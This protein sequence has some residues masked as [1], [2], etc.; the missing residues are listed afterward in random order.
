[1]K[2]IQWGIVATGAIAAKF[3]EA[4]NFES[5]RAGR[6]I[7]AAVASRD[8]KKAAEFAAKWNIARY[9][10]SYA[11]LFADPAIDAVYIATPH[12]LHAEL[13][14][15]ALEAGKAVLC[16]KPV[17]LDA[18][19]FRPVIEAAKRTNRFFMEAMW[20][21]FNPSFRKA[22]VWIAEGV[23]GEPKYLR[24]DFFLD[25][26]FN[27]E[28]RLYNP[29]LGGGALLDLGIYP[30]TCAA[31]L[32]GGKKPAYLTA[33]MH[34]GSTGVDLY[35]KAHMVWDDGLIADLSSAINLQGVE[36]LRSA[37]II[38][39]TGSIILPFFWMAE[40]AVLLDAQGNEVETFNAPFECNG[41]EYE[42]REVE[43]C[44]I[45]GK[46]ESPVQTW[47]DSIMVMEI[48]DDIRKVSKQTNGGK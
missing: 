5:A 20:M 23:I 43:E 15:A 17:S 48:L 42:I 33:I 40:K 26:P 28:S 37:V 3:A 46:T 45:E 11:E 16:E 21:K 7:L 30:V 13:S 10:G 4:C 1:M 2:Q 6:S 9:Y 41:Y 19:E 36:E 12:N 25:S 35:N 44:L 31:V 18:K 22:F 24:S 27:P 8:R 38:G 29:A 34:T 47:A 32:S 39:D 14:I